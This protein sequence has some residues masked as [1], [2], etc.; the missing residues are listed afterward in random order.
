VPSVQPYV[1]DTEIETASGMDFEADFSFLFAISGP[2]GT[3]RTADWGHGKQGT[4][5]AIQQYG[6]GKENEADF[7]GADLVL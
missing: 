2:C 7:C 6:L 3:V 4:E 1:F 5:V